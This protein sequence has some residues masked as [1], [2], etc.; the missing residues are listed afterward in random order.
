MDAEPE[1]AALPGVAGAQWTGSQWGQEGTHGFCHPSAET[2]RSA[3][4]VL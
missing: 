4:H 1:S 2:C 3:Q